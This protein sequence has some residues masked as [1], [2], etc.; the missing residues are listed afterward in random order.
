M[1]VLATPP[2]VALPDEIAV[3]IKDHQFSPAGIHVPIGKPVILGITDQD[4]TV[5]E[6]DSS[7]PKVEKA[8]V[9]GTW[10]IVRLRPLGVGRYPF[11]DAYHSGTESR[12]PAP[13]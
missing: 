1:P 13:Q 4:A 8:I 11:M 2:G 9:G 7:A 12:K 3:T 6:F 10:E 5:E